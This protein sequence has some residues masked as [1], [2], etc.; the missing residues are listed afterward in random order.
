MKSPFI[1]MMI[2]RIVYGKSRAY[3]CVDDYFTLL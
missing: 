1:S 3:E 2:A